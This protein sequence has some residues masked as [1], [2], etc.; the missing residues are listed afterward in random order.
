MNCNRAMILPPANSIG[1]HRTL[2]LADFNLRIKGVDIEK[3]QIPTKNEIGC[4]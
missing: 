1:I 2:D 4:S 3:R